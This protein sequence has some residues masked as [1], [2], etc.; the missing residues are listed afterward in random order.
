MPCATDF[1]KIYKISHLGNHVRDDVSQEAA[2]PPRS[3]SG[4]DNVSESEGK[5][6]IEVTGKPSFSSSETR[7][8]QLELWNRVVTPVIVPVQITGFKPKVHVLFAEVNMLLGNLNTRRTQQFIM[9][10]HKKK[11]HQ[12]NQCHPTLVSTILSQIYKA[13]EKRHPVFQYL[14]GEPHQLDDGSMDEV[15]RRIVRDR[16]IVLPYQ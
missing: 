4:V 14:L 3:S 6:A 11:A 1:P 16:V 13:P 7:K 8:G 9:S 2:I 10:I 12:L 15:E 5:L